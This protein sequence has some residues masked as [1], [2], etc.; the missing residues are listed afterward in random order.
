[1]KRRP[2]SRDRGGPVPSGGAGGGDLSRSWSGGEVPDEAGIGRRTEVAVIPISAPAGRREA[3][4]L[5]VRVVRR[6]GA[7]VPVLAVVTV[8]T[9]A[10]EVLL[11]ATLGRTL[12]AV[13]AGRGTGGWA[14]ASVILIGV[15]V[16]GDA[17][18]ELAA[19]MSRARA[20][21]WLRHALV[22]HVL[23]AGHG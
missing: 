9:A 13:L 17:L 4:R 10:A 18:G 1:M 7:W 19:G 14:A 15:C 20:T 11:P 16:A 12:D 3:D 22:G 21:A 5:L 8:V 23:A 2:A 6:G